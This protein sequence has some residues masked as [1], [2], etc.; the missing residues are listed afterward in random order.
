MPSV[1]WRLDVAIGRLYA[2]WPG[3][4]ASVT[5]GRQATAFHARP[6]IRAPVKAN[7]R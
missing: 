3:P 7:P 6:A 4:V 2:P 5:K 1:F